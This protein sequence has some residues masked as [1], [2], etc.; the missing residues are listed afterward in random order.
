MKG[1]PGFK[2]SRNEPDAEPVFRKRRGKLV[3]VPP[4]WVGHIVHKQTRNERQPVKRRTR[5]EKP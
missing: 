1:K 5:K 2:T 3:Q 4:E